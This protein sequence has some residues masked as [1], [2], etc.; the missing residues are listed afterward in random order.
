VVECLLSKYKALSSNS[1]TAKKKKR[2]GKRK[3]GHNKVKY[4]HVNS[5]RFG[6]WLNA[7]I[8]QLCKNLEKL[9][10]FYFSLNTC[11]FLFSIQM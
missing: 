8:W 1:S 10:S 3:W 5:S 6:G 4:W 2:E 7:S 11:S 9:I